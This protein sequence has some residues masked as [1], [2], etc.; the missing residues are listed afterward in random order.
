[1]YPS[2]H[3]PI[4]TSNCLHNNQSIHKSIYTQIHL[5]TN[6]TIH[7]SIDPFIHL[8]LSLSLFHCCPLSS[9][10]FSR[11]ILYHLLYLSL[12]SLSLSHTHTHIGIS[13]LSACALS[14]PH[15]ISQSVSPSV[16]MHDYYI[17]NCA[18]YLNQFMFAL[19]N[20]ILNNNN[21]QNILPT[22]GI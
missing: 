9:S 20:A 11:P 8:S 14:I 6:P 4:Y 10:F 22:S 19:Y 1:M 5:Y 16:S 21:M 7:Q 3:K 12:S 17:N 2:M 18:E 15:S 13:V